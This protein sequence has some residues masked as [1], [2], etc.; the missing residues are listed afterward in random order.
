M[1]SSHELTYYLNSECV[2]Q[3][4]KTVKYPAPTFCVHME[5]LALKKLLTLEQR[6]ELEAKLSRVFKE[7]IKD[8]SAEFQ[9]ILVDDL[10]TAF[11]NRRNVLMRAQEKR[12]N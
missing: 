11:E 10:V 2:F 1:K 7:K 12:S 9:K 4:H 8:L 5:G 3:I 6:D